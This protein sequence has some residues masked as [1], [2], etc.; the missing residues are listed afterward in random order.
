MSVTLGKLER[1]DPRTA[2]PHE[3]AA[4][5]PWLASEEGLQLLGEA[6][7]MTLERQAEEQP[8]GRFNAD[9]L[10]R[11]ADVPE[12]H[13]V[14][15]ENQLEETDH[16]HLGQLMTYAA[17]LDAMTIIWVARSFRDEHR[18]A[19]DWLNDVSHE[20]I[21]FFGVEIEL[22]RIGTSPPAPKF[23]VVSRPNDWSR[24]VQDAKAADAT[25]S[26]LRAQQ[27]RFWEGLRAL[28]EQRK[29]PVRTQAPR[30]QAYTWASLGRSG[31][32]LLPSMNT[33]DRSLTVECILQ[34]SAARS[35]FKQLQAQKPQIEAEIGQ[36][37][38]WEMP[39]DRKRCSILLTRPNADA[40]KEADWP[41]LH[42]W[43]A[44]TLALFHK[45]F[46]VR[47]AA[48]ED[49]PEESVDAAEE[50]AAG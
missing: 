2:W 48:L 7:G 46:A 40:T 21:A 27:R 9:I 24:E 14:V 16:R 26:P 44:D 23:N 30:P 20:D 41:V 29:G 11:R 4:F 39:A 50:G 38:Q 36:P 28:L 5:T 32:G 12:E 8:V 34:G 6:L 37:L 18:A 31:I 25:A 15:I 22:W 10:A 33:R 49:V 42:A 43:M 1:V 35:W 45:V 47:A 3:A 17:G 13:F 19:L